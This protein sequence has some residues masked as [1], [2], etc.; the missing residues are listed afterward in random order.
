MIAVLRKLL[1]DE[2]RWRTETYEFVSHVP[3]IDLLFGSDRER[4]AIEAG[5]PW[6]DIAAAWEPEEAAFARRRQA[7]LLYS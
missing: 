7:A 6:R 5:V 4:Q 3:A 2:F 1:G